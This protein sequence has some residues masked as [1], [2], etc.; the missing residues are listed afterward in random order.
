MPIS[1]LTMIVWT[2]YEAAS[3]I[4]LHIK[5]DNFIFRRAQICVTHW[6]RFPVRK[7]VNFTE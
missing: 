4:G 3:A 2:R 1:G 5:G 6:P 7:S